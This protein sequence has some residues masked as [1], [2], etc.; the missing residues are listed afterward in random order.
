MTK[1]VL[2][3]M[4]NPNIDAILHPTTREIQKRDPVQLDIDK[5]IE[6]AKETGTTLDIDSYPDRLDLKD[7]YIRKA[8]QAG[9]KLGIK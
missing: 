3:V 8:V 2:K 1:R 7:E 6:A 4:E 5:I 9:A